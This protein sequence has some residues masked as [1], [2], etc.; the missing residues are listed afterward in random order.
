MEYFEEVFT[1]IWFNRVYTFF[2]VMRPVSHK[3]SL[4]LMLEHEPSMRLVE[5]GVMHSFNAHNTL[6]LLELF[7]NACRFLASF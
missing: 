1:I 2:R 4:P 3:K 6:H 7:Y 5:S